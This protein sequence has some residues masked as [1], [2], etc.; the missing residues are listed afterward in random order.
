MA[1]VTKVYKNWPAYD[2]DLANKAYVDTQVEDIAS[3]D[4]TVLKK[5]VEKNTQDI[6]TAESDIINLNNNKLNTSVYNTFISEQY[7]PLVIKVDNKIE[8]YYQ[9]T[10]PSLAWL[11]ALEKDTHIGDI[12]YDTI[13][14]KTLV[15][16]KDSSTNPPTY[17]WQWQNVPIELI[18]SVNGKATIY[19][20]VIPTNYKTGDYWIIPTNCFNNTYSI[21]DVSSQT[22][23]YV[24]GMNL[25][26]GRYTLI[27]DAVDS[28]NKII[29][30]TVDVPE[31]SNYSLTS[32]ITNEGLT[33]TI[34]SVSDFILPI[35]CYG[36]SICVA[37]SNGT[38][39]SAGDWVPRN[40]YVPSDLAGRY[41]LAEDVNNY[42]SELN[43]TIE[44]NYSTLNGQINNNYSAL[45]GKIDNNYS[46]LDGKI[47]NNYNT[48]DGKIDGV[49]DKIDG[50][51][52]KY[53]GLING[54][55]G[56][57]VAIERLEDRI[58]ANIRG[59][60]GNNL[61][62]NSVG[63][64]NR[65][66]WNIPQANTIEQ[67]YNTFAGQI[68]TIYF[69]YRKNDYNNVKI[70]LGQYE[71]GNFTEIYT[72][73]N[74]TD[75]VNEWTDVQ[76]QYT[77]TINK[78]VIRFNST[79]DGVQNNEAESN[80]SS[81][82]MLQFANGLY[83]TDLMIGY[84]EKQPWTPYFNEVYGKTYNLDEYGL[85]IRENA[86]DKYS[87]LDANSLDF[88]NSN[89]DIESEFGKSRSST[90]NIYIAN[91]FNIGNLNM[92]KLD[93]DNIIEY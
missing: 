67:T 55:E 14:Q 26:F 43:G 29:H 77:S 15:Y 3:G 50:V 54:P 11:T 38:S 56:V 62:R 44:G 2:D 57:K 79:F 7:N 1:N 93:D 51:D 36:G 17:N 47:N 64:R 8:S 48:L 68:V 19:S 22:G 52:D 39:Y 73:L 58:V 18:D 92:I 20:G 88:R 21:S 53:D 24:V 40:D 41:S 49:D 10:D 33:L 75:Q 61:L 59:T 63:F 90:D 25:K 65:L 72:I 34:N 66:Y 91:S 30:Y 16:Y 71:N 87:H 45:D 83:I 82:S 60:G 85:D 31:H 23:N 42:I 78:P 76:F 69:R 9:S 5:A 81:G 86:S 89:G 37:T 13:T 6:N 4:L 84:G 46:A 27:V 12:W 35:N 32:A 70:V 74:T 80:G 28:N